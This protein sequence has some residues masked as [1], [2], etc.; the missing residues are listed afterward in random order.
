MDYLSPVYVHRLAH[1]VGKDAFELDAVGM[2]T[3]YSLLAGVVPHL[4]ADD[5]IG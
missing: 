1:V 3:K 5:V 4:A 2:L